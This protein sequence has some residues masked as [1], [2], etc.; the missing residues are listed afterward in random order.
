[1]LKLLVPAE[2][3]KPRQTL[4]GQTPLLHCSAR[5]VLGTVVAVHPKSKQALVMHRTAR[6]LSSTISPPESHRSMKQ[7]IAFM[8]PVCILSCLMFQL[9]I[10]Y[11]DPPSEIRHAS[12][13]LCVLL[14][15]RFNLCWPVLL[16]HI[17][18]I[19][20]YSWLFSRN[21]WDVKWA[22]MCGGKRLLHRRNL[23][24]FSP[25]QLKCSK[26]EPEDLRTFK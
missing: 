13:Q 6:S 21:T 25:S 1:M 5:I 18:H 9:V 3:P 26:D 16:G 11:R 19:P 7:S 14:L 24:L 10:Q 15:T 4:V 12:H 22:R 2:Q 17:C 20:V 8:K 23:S